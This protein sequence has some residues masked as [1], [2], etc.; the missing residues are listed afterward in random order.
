MLAGSQ[1]TEASVNSVREL[2]QKAELWKNT[3]LKK[4]EGSF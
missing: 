2:V 3:Y 1:Y 4:P